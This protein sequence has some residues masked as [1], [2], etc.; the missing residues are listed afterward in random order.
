VI[1][2]D[3]NVV[4]ELMRPVPAPRVDQWI[5]GQEPGTM[6]LS[7][8]TLAEILYGIERLPDGRRRTDLAAR[9]R[10]FLDLG[11]GGAVHAVDPGT[12]EQYAAIRAA[13]DAAGRPMT[14]FDALI[15]A[16]ARVHAAALATRNTGDF[17]GC[18]LEL[19]NPWA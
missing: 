16:T 10:V 18:G 7:V 6:A 4:S 11:F 13:R 19:V 14:S 3:T 17:A 8:I 9:F 12:A 2:L 15:A 5:A 1:L